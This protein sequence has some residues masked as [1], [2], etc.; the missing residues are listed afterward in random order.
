MTERVRFDHNAMRKRDIIP[1]LTAGTYGEFDARWL[2]PMVLEA[3]L[4]GSRGVTY[5]WF[6]DF[7]PMDFYYHAK[8]LAALA[9]Y[10]SLL[11]SGK[12]ISYQGNNPA[13]HYTAFASKSEALVLV[14]NYGNTAKTKV[15]LALPVET[16][17]QA[18][19]DGKP[20]EV[21]GGSVALDVPPGEFRLVVFRGAL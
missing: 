15:R 21:Q 12:P 3:I 10:E 6:G 1:W 5:Y 9:P 20:L 11:Q 2:E 16:A 19:V 14:G 17:R 18:T 13:L 8:A 7:D 4:N